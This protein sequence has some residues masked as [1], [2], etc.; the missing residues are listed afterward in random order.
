MFAGHVA[1]FLLL[2]SRTVFER[3][4]G[5]VPKMMTRFGDPRVAL[6]LQSAA[7]LIFFLGGGQSAWH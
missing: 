7:S 4:H 6:Q 2:A 3:F 1:D 5:G